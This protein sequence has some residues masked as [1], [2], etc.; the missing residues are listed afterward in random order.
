MWAEDAT[1]HNR[2]P[3]MYS[4]LIL[5]SLLPCCHLQARQFLAEAQLLKQL[6]KTGVCHDNIVR[7]VGVMTQVHA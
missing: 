5:A 7:L 4:P 6:W 1:E 2:E 3:A